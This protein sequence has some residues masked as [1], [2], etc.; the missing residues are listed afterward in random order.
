MGNYEAL[1]DLQKR[2]LIEWMFYYIPW[3]SSFKMN[4]ENLIKALPD[5]YNAFTGAKFKVVRDDGTNL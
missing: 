5:A 2:Q 1:S 4:R 3:D